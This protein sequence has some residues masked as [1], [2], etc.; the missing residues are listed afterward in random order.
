MKKHSI[1][2]TE[3]AKIVLQKRYLK[4]D[5]QGNFEAP[6]TMFERVS[7]AIVEAEKR[8]KTGDVQSFAQKYYDIMTEL[9]FLPNSPTLMNAGRDLGQLSAC[10]TSG[11]GFHGGYF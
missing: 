2:L 10:L 8:Y 9:K 4:K 3:N 7:V 11:G 5:E 1:N 6:E